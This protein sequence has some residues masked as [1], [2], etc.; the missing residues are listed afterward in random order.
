VREKR[1]AVSEEAAFKAKAPSVESVGTFA[2]EE[3][4]ARRRDNKKIPCAEKREEILRRLTERIIS[5]QST[6]LVIW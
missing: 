3:C 4:R 5:M 1:I 2:G 6:V